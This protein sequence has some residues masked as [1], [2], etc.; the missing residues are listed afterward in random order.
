MGGKDHEN[1]PKIPGGRPAARP[2][3]S[4]ARS[5]VLDGKP[6]DKFVGLGVQQSAADDPFDVTGVF[7]QSLERCFLFRQSR[8]QFRQ[9]GPGAGFLQLELRKLTARLPKETR[10]GHP[11]ADKEHEIKGENE[12]A[13][14][15]VHLG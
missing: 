13:N 9:A 10:R 2:P 8:L 12:F 14:V 15:H 7:A 4:K 5:S 11:N 1:P 3:G 6:K